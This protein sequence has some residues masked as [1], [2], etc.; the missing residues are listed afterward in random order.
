MHGQQLL[1]RA[2]AGVGSQSIGWCYV[3]GSATGGC[4]QAIKFGGQGPP[5]GTTISLE[6]IEQSGGA[7]A[8]AGGE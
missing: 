4:P 7:A 6:C 5:A 2:R 1:L 3:S 8:D